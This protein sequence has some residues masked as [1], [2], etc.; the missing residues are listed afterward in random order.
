MRY[1]SYL[2]LSSMLVMGFGHEMFQVSQMEEI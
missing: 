2:R 1:D